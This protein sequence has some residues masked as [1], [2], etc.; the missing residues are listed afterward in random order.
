M[1]VVLGLS[2]V[3]S[4]GG[5]LF[6]GRQSPIVFLL[7]LFSAHFIY[8]LIGVPVVVFAL[9]SA[10]N[11][12]R[13]SV[14][15]AHFGFGITVLSIL[16]AC[17]CKQTGTFAMRPGEMRTLAGY[18]VFFQSI[19]LVEG[20]N[21]MSHQGVFQIRSGT[22]QANTITLSP[23]KRVYFAQWLNVSEVAISPGV[24]REFYV[25]LGEQ[26]APNYWSVRIQLQPFVRGVWLGA[27]LMAF[28]GAM[29]L[30]RRKRW[31]YALFKTYITE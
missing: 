5:W 30:L 19:K 18:Q 20:E 31:G 14:F 17:F 23:E 1:S 8:F 2:L 3:L 13:L 28:G 22:Q 10:F 15:L 6:L 24:W 16:L 4:L 25:A 26:L 12:S 9:I 29:S 27:I 11:L 7:N 21:Y